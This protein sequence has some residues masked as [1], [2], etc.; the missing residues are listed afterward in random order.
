MRL[1]G[2]DLVRRNRELEQLDDPQLVS[3]DIGDR[4]LQPV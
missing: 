3:D 1:A 4:E 2:P